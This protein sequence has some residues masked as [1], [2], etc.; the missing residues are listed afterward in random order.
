ML[1][2]KNKVK[3][4]ESWLS[5]LCLRDTNNFFDQPTFYEIKKEQKCSFVLNANRI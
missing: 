5:N 1:V 3:L 2:T 4:V